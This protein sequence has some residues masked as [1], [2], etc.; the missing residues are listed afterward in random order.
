M[1][2][3]TLIELIKA[4]GWRLDRV[5]GSHNIFV[6]DGEPGHINIPHPRKDVSIGVYRDVKKKA[7]L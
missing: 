1:D 5:N 3:K 2:S 4:K 6:K 7:G